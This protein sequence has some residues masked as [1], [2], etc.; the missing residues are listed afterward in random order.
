MQLSCLPVSLYRDFSAGRWSLGDWFRFAAGLGLAGADISVAHLESATPSH[1][2]R[3]RR[4]AES[5]GV[6]ICMVVG[7]TDFTHPD[8]GERAR[9]VELLRRHIETA[10]GLGAPFI[11]VTAGQRWPD[12]P[13]SEGIEWAAAGLTACLDEAAAAGVTLV[14]ENHSIGY[15]W[16]HFDFSQPADI[17]LEIVRRTEGSG[18]RL[19]FDTANNLAYGDDP[20]AVLE[21]VQPRVS[22]VHASDIARAGSYEPVVLGSGVVPNVDLL[23]RLRAAG[24]D[25]WVSVEEASRSGE[26]GFRQ[27]IPAAR[28][29][30]EEAG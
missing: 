18:L 4:E 6:C 24:W 2:E 9:Q 16:Q 7:Y 20:L 27:A 1:L 5:A 12:T 14:Y 26:E 29:L 22:V 25:G 21:A 23:H 11:R 30:W 15:G 3:L 8:T 19:L 13:R 17:F 10:A 28:R